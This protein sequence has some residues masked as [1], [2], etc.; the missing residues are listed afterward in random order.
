MAMVVPK[1]KQ[2]KLLVSRVLANMYL[3]HRIYSAVRMVT[4]VYFDW[5]IRSRKK[6]V[7]V[8][9][10]NDAVLFPSFYEASTHEVGLINYYIDG[11][12]IHSMQVHHQSFCVLFY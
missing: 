6:S 9:D 7:A 12:K 8:F 2:F 1:S 4:V 3:R 10:Y 11:C 5:W